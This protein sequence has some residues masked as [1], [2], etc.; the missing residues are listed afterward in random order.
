MRTGS[1]QSC[2][3]MTTMYQVERVLLTCVIVYIDHGQSKYLLLYNYRLHSF[4]SNSRNCGIIFQLLKS[5]FSLTLWATMITQ[6]LRTSN[7]VR[8]I[9]FFHLFSFH[10]FSHLICTKI[11]EKLVRSVF[12]SNS[13]FLMKLHGRF[14]LCVN[15]FLVRMVRISTSL[16][17]FP[18]LFSFEPG[19]IAKRFIFGQFDRA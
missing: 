15:Q 19:F 7:N 1:S 4:Q 5:L 13:Y 9:Y 17:M 18:K 3:C 16:S 10:L 12:I 2:L 11:R 6:L 8:S 14:M